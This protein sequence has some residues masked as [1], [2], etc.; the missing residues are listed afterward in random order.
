MHHNLP[1]KWYWSRDADQ[2]R[3]L[4]RE[5]RSL[6]RTLDYATLVARQLDMKLISTNLDSTLAIR[7]LCSSPYFPIDASCQLRE[8]T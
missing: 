3:S 6:R 2:I 4:L 7:V 5:L 8:S 1:T